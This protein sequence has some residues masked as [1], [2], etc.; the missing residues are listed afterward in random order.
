MAFPLVAL[1]PVLGNLLDKLIPDPQAAADA[2][3]KLLEM[4][5]RGELAALE[6]EKSIVDGQNVTNAAEAASGSL[7]RGGWRPAVGWICAAAFGVQFVL[8]PLLPWAVKVIGAGDVPPIPQMNME[9]LLT[10]LLGMLG[11]GGMRTIE[12]LNGK[13]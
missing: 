11:L 2:K 10:V 3:I 9:L 12:R 4:T 8:A 13:A 1:I 5:Q 7:F 6:F